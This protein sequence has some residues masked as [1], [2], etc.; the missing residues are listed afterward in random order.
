MVLHSIRTLLCLLYFIGLREY[1]LHGQ[2][3]KRD[4]LIL[5]VDDLEKISQ[6]CNYP[7]NLLSDSLNVKE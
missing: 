6:K 3:G 5:L 1:V 7:F 2:Y 4:A